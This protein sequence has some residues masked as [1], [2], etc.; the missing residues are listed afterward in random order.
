MVSAPYMLPV[1]EQYRPVME[2]SG[3][4]VIVAPVRERLNEEELL[5]VITDVDGV[6]CGDDQFTERVMLA[7]S[8][9][10]VISKWGTGID[11]IDLQAAQRIGIKVCNTP[12]AF[13]DPVADTVMGYVLCFA[14]QLPWLD[15]DIRN[16]QW[17]KR[18]GVALN[19]R[20]LG[21]VGVGDVGKAVVRR[22]V[23]FGMEVLGNDIVEIPGAF[24]EETGLQAVSLENLLARC[25]YVSLHCTLNPTTQHLIGPAQ[26]HKM[27]STAYLINPC[28]G[29]VVDEPALA[30]A[31]QEGTIAGAALDVFEDE[32]LPEDSPLRTL[33]NCLL[34]P[35]NANSSPRA[36]EKVHESTIRN[37]VEGLKAAG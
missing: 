20:T 4:D 17:Q 18:P 33:D 35:H 36:W 3:I 34:A 14:R 10:K 15:R 37:L 2:E 12:G 27:K 11:S 7:A 24:L 1:L 6:I 19:E 9:L 29:P 5:S 28:R 31:L 13:T 21:V 8:K 22:A 30:R 16:G 32:P 25:D 23:A 26:L